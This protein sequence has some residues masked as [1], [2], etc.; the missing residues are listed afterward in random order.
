MKRWMTT[1]IMFSAMALAFLLVGCEGDQGPAGPPGTATCM[2]CHTNEYDAELAISLLPVRTEYEHSLHAT[3]ETSVRNDA[4]CARCHTNEGFQ[5]YVNTGE[6]K[7]VPFS[8]EIGCFTCHAPHVNETF[9]VRVTEAVTITGM[10]TYDKGTS[11]TCATCHQARPASPAIPESGTLQITNRRWGPHHSCQSNILAGIGAY[12][13][14]DTPYR[15]DAAHNSITNGCVHCHMAEPPEDYAGGHS[16]AVLVEGADA[17]NPNG[18]TDGCH[19][20]WSPEEAFTHVR[21]TQED[22]HER[23]HELGLDMLALGWMNPDA[24]NG[25]V[26]PGTYTPD[27]LGAMWN[28]MLLDEDFSGSVHNVIYAG[29][30]LEATQAFVTGQM[31]LRGLASAHAGDQK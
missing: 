5:H 13:F 25:F 6:E 8:T 10:G 17:I 20:D 24:T 22:F 19:S 2:N 16:F 26:N 18:C 9:E 23:L 1:G 30:V 31:A 21:D 27:Q 28:W 11:N 14:G 12:Q 3:G 7:A 4:S 29:D 15:N